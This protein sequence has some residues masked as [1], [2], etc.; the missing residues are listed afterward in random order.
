MESGMKVNLVEK[1]ASGGLFTLDERLWSKE[2]IEAL[3]HVNY[4]TI[5]GAEYE[6][7]EGRL[8]LDQGVME[9][10]VQKVTHR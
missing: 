9:L 4:L 2:M 8:N 3:H 6:T 5:N 7:I 1:L 10:L